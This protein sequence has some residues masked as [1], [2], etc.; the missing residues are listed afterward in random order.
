MKLW[1]SKC[2]KMKL[3][4]ESNLFCISSSIL[5]STITSRIF[6][7]LFPCWKWLSDPISSTDP[8]DYKTGRLQRQIGIPLPAADTFATSTVFMY[9]ELLPVVKLSAP[10]KKLMFTDSE[11]KYETNLAQ[12]VTGWHLY[13]K[14]HLSYLM[15]FYIGWL[16]NL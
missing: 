4:K 6:S 15:I 12:S 3:G 16:E 10:K 13:S 7:P 9:P 11:D 1:N 8:D 5:S 14:D 2:V